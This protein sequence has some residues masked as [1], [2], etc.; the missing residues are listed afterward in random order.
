M[1]VVEFPRKQ[2]ER[3]PFEEV[4]K[5]YYSEV[6]YYIRGKLNNYHDAED[7]AG[8]V[9]FYCYQNYEKYDPN[10]SSFATWLYLI[11]NSRLKNYYRDRKQTVD[12]SELEEWMFMDEPDMERAIYLEELRKFVADRL[13]SLPEKQ[14]KVVQMRYFQEREFNEIADEMG[15]TAGNARVI[16]SRAMDRL[17]K[18]FEN[19]AIDWRLS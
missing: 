11:V 12:F 2:V 3:L 15:T 19:K 8:D 17:E 6:V 16:L 13:A 7:L 14:R 9:F 1:N 10:R 5:Q 18:E 4:Y